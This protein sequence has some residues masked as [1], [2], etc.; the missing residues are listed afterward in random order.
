MLRT[1][2]LVKVLIELELETAIGLKNHTTVFTYK[3]LE[4]VFLN[5]LGVEVQNYSFASEN[6]L[7]AETGK[8]SSGHEAMRPQLGNRT[9]DMTPQLGNSPRDKAV[10][11]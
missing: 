10:R 7:T 6:F 3:Q 5:S 11:S 8:R 4:K 2:K 1:W 9:I